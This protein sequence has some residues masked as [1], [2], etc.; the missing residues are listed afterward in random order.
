MIQP[1]T[2]NDPGADAVTIT[3]PHAGLLVDVARTYND[4]YAGQWGI[5]AELCASRLRDPEAAA[6][7]LNL[8]GE[9]AAVPDFDR[10]EASIGD[11]QVVFHAR[12]HV[13]TSALDLF[14]RILCGQWDEMSWHCGMFNNG[15]RTIGLTQLRA[16]HSR[17]Y[18]D[19]VPWDERAF[20][21][22]ANAS[23]SI[24][25]ATL[26]ARIAYHAYKDLGGGTP[27]SPTFGLPDGP[28]LVEV[29]KSTPRTLPRRAANPAPGTGDAR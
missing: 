29:M 6:R 27:G 11:G 5:A 22:Y 26:P 15:L 23:I 21:P 2:T 16:V 4:V 13:V 28:V 10:L 9:A 7:E 14:M 1:T 20:P 8:C 25:Q 3:H 18:D 24:A 12:Q 19:T 17:E